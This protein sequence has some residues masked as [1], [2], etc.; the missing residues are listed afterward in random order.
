[1]TPENP[2]CTH[3]L[4]KQTLRRRILAETGVSCGI[5]AETNL[6]AP[7]QAPA[8]PQV[9]APSQALAPPQAP[10]P[11][12]PGRPLSPPPQRL[13]PFLNRPRRLPSCRKV[14][15]RKGAKLRRPRLRAGAGGGATAGA[16]ITTGG[17]QW[18]EASSTSASP[19]PH[20]RLAAVL[21]ETLM[22]HCQGRT[23]LTCCLS[24]FELLD[25][26]GYL[27]K[28]YPNRQCLPTRPRGT[29]GASSLL[30]PHTPAQRPH[31]MRFV[32]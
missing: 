26:R 29:S 4:P 23:S 19:S 11:P 8:P 16:R 21:V 25:T 31:L 13:A 32:A 2:F 28:P 12:R 30:P 1:M 24:I 14:V 5:A 9:R 17:R 20:F 7:P 6:R 18:G 27:E 10:A 3:L 15:L 22:W